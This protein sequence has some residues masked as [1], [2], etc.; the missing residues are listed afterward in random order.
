MK[1]ELKRKWFTNQSTI[2]EL[3]INGVFE[4][5][6]LEDVVREK[7]GVPVSKWKIQDV[8]AIPKGTYD[9]IITHSPRFKQRLPILLRVAGF[10]GIRIHSGNTANHTEGCIL[11][12]TTR[13]KDFVGNSRVAFGRLFRKITTALTAG[14]KVTIKIS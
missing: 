9:L 8:T 12:G 1:I 2:G 11:V 3:Y 4:C 7:E 5:F 14:K 6:T 13:A 10:T